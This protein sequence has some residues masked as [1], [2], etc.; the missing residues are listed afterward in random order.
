M[1]F[2]FLTIAPMI[3][4]S[5][6]IDTA[7]PFII[8]RL[9]NNMANLSVD[10]LSAEEEKRLE[11]LAH[12]LEQKVS[13]G[14]ATPHEVYELALIH[15]HR[16][17]YNTALALLDQAIGETED[18]EFIRTKAFIL[19][20]KG[21]FTQAKECFAQLF[22]RWKGAYAM[23]A[24]CA[25]VLGDPFS[26]FYLNEALNREKVETKQVLN[27]FF[28]TAISKSPAVPQEQKEELSALIKSL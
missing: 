4:K 25:I 19:V 1:C 28:N 6:T 13:S 17:E 24:L 12:M 14:R 3:Q 8:S 21:D 26:P 11:R 23:Y 2:C 20:E 22:G 16:K 18:P 9:N 27:A 5:S 10:G 15:Y 7:K